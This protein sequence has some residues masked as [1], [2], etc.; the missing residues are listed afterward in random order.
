MNI[1]K[2]IHNLILLAIVLTLIFNLMELYTL[3]TYGFVSKNSNVTPTQV[4]LLKDVLFWLIFFFCLILSIKNGRLKLYPSKIVFTITM[5]AFCSIVFS[6]LS[7]S[8]LLLLVGVRWFFTFFLI[9]FLYRVV[10]DELQTKI[11]IC[12]VVIF[13]IALCFQL[14]ELFYLPL[15]YGINFLGLSLRNPGIYLIP[16]TMAFFSL[17]TMWYA[18][19]FFPQKRLGMLIVK[20]LGPLSVVLTSSG[21]GIMAMVFFFSGFL[22]SNIKN[23]GVFILFL[24]IGM[25]GTFSFLPIILGRTD[26]FISFLT[27]LNIFGDTAALNHLLIS[28]SFGSATNAAVLMQGISNQQKFVADSNFTSIFYNIGFIA[29][30]LY[31]SLFIILLKKSL[32]VMQLFGIYLCFSITTISFESYPLNLIF[33]L[34]VAFYLVETKKQFYGNINSCK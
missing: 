30:L 33:A 8:F 21:T 24:I 15:F 9:N 32:A 11:A 12:M 1:R 28:S 7:Q 26:I 14:L 2:T 6:S 17:V 22:V 29:L 13:F 25:V 34:N 3:V 27:R 20:F 4:K 19:Y 5:L 31:A 23:K 16:S 18:Y 10:D